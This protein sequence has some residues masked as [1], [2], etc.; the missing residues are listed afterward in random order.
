MT[1]KRVDLPNFVPES[2]PIIQARLE[3]A[4]AFDQQLID[5]YDEGD[6]DRD[7][8]I[9]RA[10]TV[11][12]R[13]LNELVTDVNEYFDN[14]LDLHPDHRANKHEHLSIGFIIERQNEVF[15]GGNPIRDSIEDYLNEKW[16]D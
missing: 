11:H 14:I 3:R 13:V 16:V 12:E 10:S 2:A 7:D 1:V 6:P 9:A 15:G 8:A 5:S 4:R